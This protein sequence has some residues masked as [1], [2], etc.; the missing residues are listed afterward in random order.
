[1]DNG[2]VF[3]VIGGNNEGENVVQSFVRLDLEDKIF[4]VLG[5]NEA[6]THMFDN[7]DF[8]TL[9]PFR[10]ALAQELDNYNEVAFTHDYFGETL[11]FNEKTNSIALLSEVTID[12][13]SYTLTIETIGK[14][15]STDSIDI[16]LDPI[17]NTRQEEISIVDSGFMVLD[18]SLELENDSKDELSNNVLTAEDDLLTPTQQAL[19]DGASARYTEDEQIDRLQYHIYGVLDKDF[20]K[21]TLDILEEIE[22]PSK[23]RAGAYADVYW[24]R[25]N[26]FVLITNESHYNEDWI[27]EEG[28]AIIR[29]QTGT[30]VTKSM[31]LS[32]Y[33]EVEVYD[34]FM[35]DAGT[36]IIVGEFGSSETNPIQNYNR[37]FVLLINDELQIVDD[38]IID[39]EGTSCFLRTM[40]V[41]NTAVRVYLGVSDYTNLFADI[42]PDSYSVLFTIQLI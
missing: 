25:D 29:F 38:F 9:E 19:I 28:R 37:K 1:V 11:T 26:E 10:Y 40:F 32:T 13:I 7:E 2:D 20:N 36:F 27:L 23:P 21:V 31:D 34:F 30:T 5:V 42:D 3:D 35:D 22:T 8:R 24:V 12:P 39:G 33:G 6:E 41:D 14:W 18:V 16:D 17:D 15:S 4:Y